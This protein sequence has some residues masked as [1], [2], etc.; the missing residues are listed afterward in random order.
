MKA[1]KKAS[2]RHRF[3]HETVAAWERAEAVM[4]K[5]KVSMADRNVIADAFT[6]ACAASLL[7]QEGPFWRLVCRDV[8]RVGEP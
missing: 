2:P 3:D 8:A 7:L 4:K 5:Y 1:Q 6:Y